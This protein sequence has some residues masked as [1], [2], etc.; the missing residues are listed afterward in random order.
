MKDYHWLWILAAVVVIYVGYK[1]AIANGWTF[2][3]S[4]GITV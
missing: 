1:E 4:G 2:G 3:V